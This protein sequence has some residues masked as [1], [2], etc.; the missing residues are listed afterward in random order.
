MFLPLKFKK[1]S[2]DDDR[3]ELGE[4]SRLQPMNPCEDKIKCTCKVKR[5]PT[6]GECSK[7]GCDHDGTPVV[8]KVGRKRGRPVSTKIRAAKRVASAA[9]QRVD[10][11][12]DDDESDSYK[13][14]IWILRGKAQVC[15]HTRRCKNCWMRELPM[16]FA[17]SQA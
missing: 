12:S 3:G 14:C 15:V 6:C 16:V 11:S 7:C 10:E 13:S 5:C 9:I 8:V 2:V 17:V 1:N 4:L